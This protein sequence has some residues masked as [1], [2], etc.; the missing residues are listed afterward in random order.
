LYFSWAWRKYYA[1][2][3]NSCQRLFFKLLFEVRGQ[4]SLAI[5][6]DAGNPAVLYPLEGNY[7]LPS[8]Y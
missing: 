8:I 5:S 6:E 3:V 2:P 1:Y 7:L 4:V